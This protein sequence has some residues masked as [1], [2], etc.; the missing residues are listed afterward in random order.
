MLKLAA[1]LFS[2]KLISLRY[3]LL[4]RRIHRIWFTVIIEGKD[5][6]RLMGSHQRS[7]SVCTLTVKLESKRKI[8]FKIEYC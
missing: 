8:F 1:K 4:V 6:G 7:V 2:V 3:L 5:T